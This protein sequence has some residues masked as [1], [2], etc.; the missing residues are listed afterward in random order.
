MLLSL[1]FVAGVGSGFVM[2]PSATSPSRLVASA[3]LK[4]GT[5]MDEFVASQLETY[6]KNRPFFQPGDTLNVACEITE[7]TTTRVQKF[8]G[9]C[10]RR[11]GAQITETF[12]VRKM[13]SGIGV[14]RTFPLY[15]PTVKSIEVIKRGSV[16]RAKLYYL[17]QLTGKSARLKEK[18]RG[19]AYVKRMVEEQQQKQEEAAA[20]A[21]A[22]KAAEESEGEKEE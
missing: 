19:L 17:R 8:Q 15:A 22:A 10:I 3:K 20:A 14:E 6:P 16:R 4:T 12:T 13:S 5:I 21:A 11:Q 7:G 1:L 18:S 2:V 9:V